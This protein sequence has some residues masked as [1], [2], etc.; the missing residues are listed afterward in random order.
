MKTL[1]DVTFYVGD[2]RELSPSGCV[3]YCDPP[4]ADSYTF[5]ITKTRGNGT[6]DHDEFWRIMEVWSKKN[7]IYVSEKET[8]SGYECVLEKTLRSGL[9]N[10]NQDTHRVDKLFYKPATTPVMPVDIYEELGVDKNWNGFRTSPV[11]IKT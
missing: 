1:Q 10:K 9:R 6:F 2:Y 4:Y 5:R 11:Y 7:W 8:P 3:I